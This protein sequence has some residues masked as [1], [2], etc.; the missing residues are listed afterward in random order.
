MTGRR[1]ERRGR[2]TA[3][4]DP[5]PLADALGAVAGRLGFAAPDVVATV[6]ARWE[7]LVGPAVAAHARPARV[8]GD[9][10]VVVVDHPAWATQLRHLAP[11]IL[12]RV[13]ESCAPQQPPT[14]LEV[15]VRP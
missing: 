15:R 3:G 10:L 1:G 2:A 11:D 14:R 12:R 8:D 5:V 7:D 13:A 9:M 4:E 6:F